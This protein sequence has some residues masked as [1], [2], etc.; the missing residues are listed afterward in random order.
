MSDGTFTQTHKRTVDYLFVA[1]AR[2]TYSHD[3]TS[4]GTGACEL[5][6]KI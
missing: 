4:T 3:I 2:L 1:N 5:R 6:E